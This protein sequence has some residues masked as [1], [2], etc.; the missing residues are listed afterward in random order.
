M[1]KRNLNTACVFVYAW[2]WFT[3][4]AKVQHGLNKSILSDDDTPWA[5]LLNSVNVNTSWINWKSSFLEIMSLCVPFKTKRGHPGSPNLQGE[6]AFST[7]VCTK[8]QKNGP[9]SADQFFPI[10]SC[11]SRRTPSP[12][13][14]HPPTSP[15]PTLS[16]SAE[17]IFKTDCANW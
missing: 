12:K 9:S 6:K 3:T 4:W 10:A 7:L 14:V 15:C 5:S 2:L 11:N 13:A 16:A 17:P 1:R 8:K